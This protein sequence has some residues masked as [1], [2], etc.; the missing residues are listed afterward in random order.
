M[1]P[2]RERLNDLNL[3]NSLLKALAAFFWELPSVGVIAATGENAPRI[4]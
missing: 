4:A 3:R 1:R 2:W